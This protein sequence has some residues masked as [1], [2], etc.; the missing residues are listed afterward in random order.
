MEAQDKVEWL[1]ASPAEVEAQI[2]IIGGRRTQRGAVYATTTRGA[3]LEI[4]ALKHQIEAINSQGN[5]IYELQ[6][7]APTPIP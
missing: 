1:Y 4:E 5:T 6:V 2:T 3:Y 7:H